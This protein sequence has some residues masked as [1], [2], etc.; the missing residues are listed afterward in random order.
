MSL[1]KFAM[2]ALGGCSGLEVS[3]KLSGKTLL[4]SLLQPHCNFIINFTLFV[5]FNAPNCIHV[6]VTRIPV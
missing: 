1:C 5:E 2:L 4:G 3:R 6:D